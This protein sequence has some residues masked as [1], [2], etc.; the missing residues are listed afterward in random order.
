MP[1]KEK[2]PNT[3]RPAKRF[4]GN[5]PP[6]IRRSSR[7]L[8]QRASASC[9]QRS[10]CPTV[11]AG[12]CKRSAATTAD[13]GRRCLPILLEPGLRPTGETR[14]PTATEDLGRITPPWAKEATINRYTF[15][16]MCTPHATI[17]ADLLMSRFVAQRSRRTP[18]L[19]I[20]HN[21]NIAISRNN[22][23]QDE[24]RCKAK[25]RRYRGAARTHLAI[26]DVELLDRH[27]C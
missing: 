10:C 20:S 23:K 15:A 16:Q 11:P 24:Q 4:S 18:V 13:T 22:A 21:S 1:I 5:R 12:S 25:K 27:L 7:N 14:S 26:G 19:L 8:P 6:A 2:N 9:H 17:K 3:S